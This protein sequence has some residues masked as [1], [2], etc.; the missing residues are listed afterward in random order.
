MTEPASLEELRERFLSQLESI[1][2]G[3]QER[4]LQK[5]LWAFRHACKTN[6]WMP[7]EPP[8]LYYK[9]L[10]ARRE[11]SQRMTGRKHWREASIAIAEVLLEHLGK[12]EIEEVGMV[13]GSHQFPCHSLPIWNTVMHRLRKAL[14][15]T[16]HIE[17]RLRDLGIWLCGE[18]GMT[19]M[20]H[21]M[22]RNDVWGKASQA[23]RE[24]LHLKCLEKRLGRP[25][26]ISDFTDVP[27]N[28]HIF[29]G[30][31][32]GLHEQSTPQG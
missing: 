15:Q 25:L 14:D 8:D 20:E 5:A 12:G 2:E 24:V 19:T 16:Q 1:P 29:I 26:V 22:V 11:V 27:L 4:V 13:V 28:D 23:K 3:Y 7:D 18:C 31:R 10:E 32:M 6:P 9:C 21:Y 30:Y 17:E